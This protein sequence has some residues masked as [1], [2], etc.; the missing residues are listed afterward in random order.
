VD[1][2]LWAALPFIGLAG[3]FFSGLLGLGGGVVMFPLLTLAGA[4]PVKLAT[5][6][7]LIHILIAAA[8]STGSHYRAGTVDSRSGFY[9]G[10]AGIGGGLIGSLLSVPLSPRSLQFIYLCVV[11]L[12]TVMLF[13]PLPMGSETYQKGSFP[14]PAGIAVGLLVGSL[15]GLLG[16]G[17]GF[18]TVPLMTYCLKIPLKVAIGTS[19]LIILI[20]SLGT[21]WAKLGVGHIDLWITLLALI[22]SIP[23][24]LIGSYFSRKTPVQILR[25]ALIVLLIVIFIM[26]A[27]ETFA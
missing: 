9:L 8:V 25:L 5:G 23:G 16:S 22:G 27:Y 1:Q 11:G 2:I 13:I 18:I 20:T 14:K 19:L 12:A 10:L 4:V 3:G 17:G 21:L 7:N 6:T 26:V 15:A 24:A